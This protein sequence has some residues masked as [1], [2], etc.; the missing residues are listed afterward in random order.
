MNT[1][2]MKNIQVYHILS[3]SFLKIPD[4]QLIADVQDVI[5]IS[6]DADVFNLKMDYTQ[7]F[8]GPHKLLAPP[9]ESVYNSPL[10][11]VCQ[12]PLLEVRKF[13]RDAGL[14]LNTQNYLDDHIGIELEFMSYLWKYNLSEA[15]NTFVQ[16]HLAQWVPDFCNDV[17]KNAKTAFY[18]DIALFTKNIIS[19]ESES[20]NLAGVN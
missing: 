2:Q 10:K 11:L 18:R 9:W 7:L 13:Y 1:I 6:S 12:E 15:K 16:E 5:D 14:V 4:E 19:I 8:I 17:I 3:L 20:K